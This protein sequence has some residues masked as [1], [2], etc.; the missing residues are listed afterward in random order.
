MTII[1]K[2][3]LGIAAAQLMIELYKLYRAIRA[4]AQ[5]TG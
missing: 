4:P 1:E 5:K 3:L 2:V